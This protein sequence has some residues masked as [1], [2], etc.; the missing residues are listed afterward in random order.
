MSSNPIRMEWTEDDEREFQRERLQAERGDTF[1]QWFRMSDHK[2]D[3]NELR[4]YIN[5]QDSL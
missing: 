2:A 3:F 4:I 5:P 1:E